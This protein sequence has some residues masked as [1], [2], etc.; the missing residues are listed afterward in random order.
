MNRPTRTDL[1]YHANDFAALAELVDYALDSSKHHRGNPVT[2]EARADHA[3]ELA[4]ELFTECEHHRRITLS[5]TLYTG[6]DL[7]D[8]PWAVLLVVDTRREERETAHL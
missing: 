7:D 2:V 5:E 1:Y 6:L 8:R 4:R 3:G